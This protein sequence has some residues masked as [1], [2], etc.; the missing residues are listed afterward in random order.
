MMCC[1]NDTNQQ[2][3]TDILRTQRKQNTDQ[4]GRGC[5]STAADNDTQC[6]ENHPES[7]RKQI[8]EGEE[9][10]QGNRLC[11]QMAENGSGGGQGH[12]R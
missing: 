1:M 4:N 8:A 10:C 3:I 7:Y 5:L 11:L 9:E 12:K 6:L 2:R